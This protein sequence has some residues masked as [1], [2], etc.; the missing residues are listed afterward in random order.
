MTP[1]T[2]EGERRTSARNDVV[3]ATG[4]SAEGR[5]AEADLRTVIDIALLMRL[6]VQQC[7]GHIE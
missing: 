7:K 3:V 2:R 5:E 4:K 6:E 1:R